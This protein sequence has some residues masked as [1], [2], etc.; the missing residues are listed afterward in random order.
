MELLTYFSRSF[1]IVFLFVAIYH[2]FLRND[3]HY[4]T[5]RFFLLLGLIMAIIL[6]AVEL[7]YT[8]IVEA[9]RQ[10]DAFVPIKPE[11]VNAVTVD[12]EVASNINWYVVGMCIYGLVTLFFILRLFHQ[13]IQ[14]LHLLRSSKALCVDG[15]NVCVHQKVEMPF[16]FG[17]RIFINDEAY[18]TPEYAEVYSHER[19]HLVQHHWI[20]VILSE[21][22]IVF[23][24]FNPFAWYYSRLVKQN[25]EFIADQGVL[26]EGF[27]KEKYIQHIICET[28]GAEASVL[29]NHFRFSQNKRRL[30]MM[31]NN[32]KSKW[33]LLKLLLVLPLIGGLLW[34]FSE[35]VYEYS[36]NPEEVNNKTTQDKKETFTVKGRIVVSDTL[37]IQKDRNKKPELKIVE[38]ALP[39]TSIVIKGTTTGTV[40]DMNG[41]FEVPASEGDILVVSFVG[42]NTREVKVEKGKDL[43]IALSPIAY[44]LDP[45]AYRAKYK[46]KMVPPPPPSATKKEKEMIPPPPPPPTE[47]GKPVFYVV[48]D[49]PSY[50]GGMDGYFASL[51][52]WITNAK[53]KTDL[54]GVVNVQ[55]MVNAK[56]GISNIKALNR[57]D[58]KEAEH[59]VK[60]I[61][62]L[63]DWKPGEQRGKP[64]STTLIVPVEFD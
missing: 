58:E 18:L 64:V 31:K 60:I 2:L 45:S 39:G 6:P 24:W 25:L 8:V 42:F 4:S 23:Q 34:A 43:Y 7:N 22:F 19:I 52:T 36:S 12:S 57:W 63:N 54:N 1:L 29:A 61:S 26:N 32:R 44:E 55:F 16:V 38:G 35:P 3:A 27:Q 37:H 30:K 28:M 13:L 17:N 5:N 20:D 53:E 46:G 9:I 56:G 50:K 49:M 62:E 59:A 47:D 48:E 21:L 14:M 51:Y 11:V 33:R 40:A 41:S 15:V 10:D